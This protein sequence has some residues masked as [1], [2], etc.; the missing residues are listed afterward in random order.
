MPIIITDVS[1]QL[2]THIGN[3]SPDNIRNYINKGE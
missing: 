3:Y 2:N 1:L